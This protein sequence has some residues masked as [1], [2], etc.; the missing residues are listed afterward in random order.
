MPN[1][2]LFMLCNNCTIGFATAA[3]GLIVGQTDLVAMVVGPEGLVVIDLVQ[4]G[5]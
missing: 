3:P 2:R 5:K 4:A 1:I